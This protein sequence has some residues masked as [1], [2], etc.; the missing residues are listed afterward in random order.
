[1]YVQRGSLGNQQSGLGVAPLVIVGAVAAAASLIG[2]GALIVGSVKES[3]RRRQVRVAIRNLILNRPSTNPSFLAAWPK[4][5][6][7][8]YQILESEA[9]ILGMGLAFPS[10]FNAGNNV[11]LTTSSSGTHVIGLQNA[12]DMARVYVINNSLDSAAINSIFSSAMSSGANGWMTQQVLNSWKQ[13]L[14]NLK[15]LPTPI[16]LRARPKDWSF[17][18]WMI[19]GAGVITATYLGY[20]YYKISRRGGRSEYTDTMNSAG[21]AMAT[22]PDGMELDEEALAVATRNFIGESKLQKSIR[23]TFQLKS[24]M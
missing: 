14:M 24:P 23:M 18:D 12:T 4:M 3:E 20:R 19:L 9:A 17:I 7:V 13:E 8:D 2:G 10:N 5:A 11:L 22:N 21:L 16:T 1:M 15:G 6:G